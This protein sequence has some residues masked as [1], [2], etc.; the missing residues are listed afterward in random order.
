MMADQPEDSD[1]GTSDVQRRLDGMSQMI[2]AH[3]QQLQEILIQLRALATTSP[4]TSTAP[5]PTVTTL[6]IAIATMVHTKV[7]VPPTQTEVRLVTSKTLVA[8]M[9]STPTTTG[10]KATPEAR[11]ARE[12]QRH[13]LKKFYGATDRLWWPEQRNSGAFWRSEVFL[14]WVKFPIE[15]GPNRLRAKLVGWENTSGSPS[16]DDARSDAGDKKGPLC[17]H[18]VGAL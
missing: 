12:F 10:I 4:S 8:K 18:A 15:Y 16:G 11:Q 5:T 9:P 3:D 7:V 13:Q 6:E 14:G 17:S 2:S 1:R